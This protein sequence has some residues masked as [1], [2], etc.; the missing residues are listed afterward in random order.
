MRVALARWGN[1]LAVRIPKSVVEDAGLA[2][3]SEA[4]ISVVGGKI[5]MTPLAAPRYPLDRLLAGVTTDNLHAEVDTGV[6]LG[7]ESW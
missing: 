7:R 4:N 5:V 3:G 6:A 2:E 1:S